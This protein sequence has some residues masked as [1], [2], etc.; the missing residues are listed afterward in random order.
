MTGSV[1]I[2][3]HLIADLTGIPPERLREGNRIMAMLDAALRR[4]GFNCLKRVEH[5][6][7]DRGA[8]FTG[9]IL[10]AESHAAVHT[11]PEHQY[12]ALD[13]FAC[14]QHDPQ[15]VLDELCAILSPEHVRVHK[16]NRTPAVQQE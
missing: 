11:Y 7:P 12:L 3:Q 14:G 8:G 5:S 6:F 16:L 2:G 1:T 13:V 4:A 15:P 10:L 9:I